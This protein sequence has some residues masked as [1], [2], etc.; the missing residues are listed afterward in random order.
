MPENRNKIL[1][2][3][4]NG[5][6]GS[7]IT[8]IFGEEGVWL[9][10]HE[11]MD[12]TDYDSV[13]RNFEKCRPDC[14]LH[15]AAATDVDRCE[16]EVDWAFKTNVLGTQNVALACQQHPA[17]LVYVST[18]GLFN[19]TRLEA[20]TEFDSP[21]PVNVYAKTKWEGEKV[22]QNLLPRYFIVRAG[23]MIGGREK[24]KKFVSKMIDLCRK[25]DSIRVV[26]DKVGTIT[27]AKDLLQTIRR[28]IAT[29][30]YGLYH[31]ANEGICSRHDV[32]LEIAKYLKSPVR[33][34]AVNSAVFPL[35]A[36]RARS[37]AIANYKLKLLG[38]ETMRPWQEALHA[39][40]EEWK[41]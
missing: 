19:G 18:G 30:F 3:G 12:V 37:E 36:P 5:M 34:E 41:P 31:A 1:V 33:I 8:K 15:L 35:P 21:D 6:V 32:A 10:D 27:Y 26:S 9:T 39:Y 17:L 11:S 23:W 24:D 2:T 25:Q 4:A 29:P 13:L 16:V 7:Y 20:Y 28:L 40:L 22:V 14:V 38:L